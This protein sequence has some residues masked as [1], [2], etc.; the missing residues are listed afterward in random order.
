MTRIIRCPSCATVYAL[1]AAQIQAAHGWLRCGKCQE[2]FNGTGLDVPASPV[3]LAH[4]SDRL[5]AQ[6]T[7]PVLAQP[8]SRVALDD[9]LLRE[10]RSGPASTLDPGVSADLMDFSEALATFKP[11]VPTHEPSVRGPEETGPAPTRL[12]QYATA[13]ALALL[14]MGQFFFFQR[15]A[16]AALWPNSQPVLESLCRP[17]HCQLKPWMNAKALE[18]EGASFAQSGQSFVL[19]WSLRNTGPLTVATTSLELT[20][21]DGSNNP[22][23][24]RIFLPDEV[25]APETLSPGQVWNGSLTVR[26]DPSLVFSHYRLLNFYP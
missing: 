1:D 6:A 15:H 19:N 16:M 4:A 10:D 26:V 2:V 7:D 18:I 8:V 12:L 11:Q 20:L 5:G 22:V 9:L 24:R 23:A 25:Q 13:A 21:L 3:L 14:L 17:L